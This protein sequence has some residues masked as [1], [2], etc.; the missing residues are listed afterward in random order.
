MDKFP[1]RYKNQHFA[2]MGKQRNLGKERKKM[3]VT[4]ITSPADA[5]VPAVH[6]LT[7]KQFYDE[8]N[9]F[10]A[11]KMAKKMLNAGLI[12]SEEYDRIL[13]ES[14]KIFVPYLAEIL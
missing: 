5:P 6:R 9:Y 11:E 1:W 4:K 3:Q 13:D 14:R 10:R 7:E 2:G 12:N 8:I